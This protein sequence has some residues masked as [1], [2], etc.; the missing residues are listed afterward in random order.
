[1]NKFLTIAILICIANTAS[2][3]RWF[4]D[5]QK[6][7][8]QFSGEMESGPVTGTFS[9]Y[10]VDM[11]FDPKSLGNAYLKARIDTPSVNTQNKQRDA[12]LAQQ[13]WL[14]TTMFPTAVFESNEITT[15]DGITFLA[16]GTLTLRGVTGPVDLS[17]TF[18]KDSKYDFAQL[19]GTARIKRLNFG[20]GQGNW[21]DTSVVG[22]PIKIVVDLYMRRTLE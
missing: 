22:N 4:A 10:W 16:T 20:V 5:P 13:E 15:A 3:E 6:S 18:E 11:N 21:L 8:I 1:M 12:T 9:K 14:Y 7:K 17:F 19:V 2:A